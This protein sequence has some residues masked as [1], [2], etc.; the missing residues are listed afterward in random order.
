MNYQQYLCVHI[1]QSIYYKPILMQ[2]ALI[3]RYIN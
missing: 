1:D 2:I 3:I